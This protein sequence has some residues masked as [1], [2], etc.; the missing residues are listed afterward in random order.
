VIFLNNSSSVKFAC[1]R[2]QIHPALTG[3][4]VDCIV[5]LPS[6]TKNSV[7]FSSIELMMLP[8]QLV[9]MLFKVT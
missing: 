1:G 2:L 8:D 5:K 7:V 9:V 6:V 4:V 3:F